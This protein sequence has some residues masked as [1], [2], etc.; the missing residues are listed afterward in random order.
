MIVYASFGRRLWAFLLSLLLDAIVFGALW[1]VTGGERIGWTFGLWYLIH[2]VGLVTEGGS[3]GHRLAGLRVVRRDGT[4]LGVINALIRQI[5]L[6]CAAIPPLGFG[7][8]WML[9]ED[10]RRGWHDL[11]GG[12]VVVRELPV[13]NEVAPSWANDPPWHRAPNDAV[14]DT[15]PQP[16]ALGPD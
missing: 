8:L 6:V 5:V 9:D 13:A 1:A 12:S 10:E 2:H 11:A 15:P 16:A 3:L 14:A 7:V 4:R